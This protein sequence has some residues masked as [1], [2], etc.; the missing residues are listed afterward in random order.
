M[1][2]IQN[3]GPQVCYHCSVAEAIEDMTL[4]SQYLLLRCI[5][6]LLRK[7]IRLGVDSVSP[8]KVH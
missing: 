8:F 4:I 1:L 5:F 3:A 2:W 6:K 7:K